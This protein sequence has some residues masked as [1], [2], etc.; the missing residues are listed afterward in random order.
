M[1]I[2]AQLLLVPLLRLR[3]VKIIDDF[4]CSTVTVL[5][6]HIK[7]CPGWTH[8]LL[9]TSWQLILNIALS[10]NYLI[11]S[12]Q[13]YK[14]TA[15]EVD[16][17]INVGFIKEIQYPQW[18]ANIVPVL[19]KKKGQVRMC[20]DFRDINRT[21][22]KD[23]F[24]TPM[25]EMV[26][27]ATTGYGAL[28]FMDGFSGYNQIKMDENDAYDMAF[29]TP[30][31][32]Y[33]YTLMPFDLENAGAKYQRAMTVVFDELIHQSV[34]CYIDDLVVKTRER[35]H[36]QEDLRQVFERFRKY[37]LRMN[38]LKCAFAVQSG[39]FLGFIIRQ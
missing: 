10:S 11:A 30:K 15:L 25:T 9:L 20:V 18:L 5:H 28:S 35:R 37:Q 32:N 24:P 22:P 29:R 6:G 31:G 27:D 2:R 13:S 8:R 21:C 14:M 23:D 12:D 26:I 36:H 4:L 7:K 1:T 19:K 39:V 33:Y 3:S 16:K 34:E 17:L 38:P